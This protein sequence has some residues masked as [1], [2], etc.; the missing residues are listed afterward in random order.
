MLR[1]FQK[2]QRVGCFIDSC[3]ASIQFEPLS[4]VYG[5]NC[6]GKSTLCDILRSLAENNPD[7]MRHRLSIPNPDNSAQQVQ[8][9][10]TVPGQVGEQTMLFDQNG[11][12]PCFP[13]SLRLLVFDTDFIH[14]NVFTGLSIERRNQENITQFVLG[15]ASVR[16]AERIAQKNSRLRALN[17]TLR[18]LESTAFEGLSDIPSFIRLQITHTPEEIESDIVGL[19]AELEE[20]RNLAQNLDQAIIR[21]V[22]APIG[23]ATNIEDFVGRVNTTLRSSFQQAH[24]EASFRVREHILLK[25]QDNQTT[26]TWIGSGLDQVQVDNCPFCGQELSAVAVQL[27]A[28]YKEFF[29]EAFD[30]FVNDITCKL[31]DHEE[32]FRGLICSHIPERIALNSNAC[33]QYPEL[34]REEVY[35]NQLQAAD[36]IAD[37]LRSALDRWSEAYR[38]AE[39]DLASKFEQKRQAMHSATD[40][41]ECSGTIQA[42]GGLCSLVSRYDAAVNEL[43][44]KIEEF[45]EGLNTAHV[46]NKISEIE[47]QV[48]DK[49]LNLRRARS[50]TACESYLSTTTEKD[51]VV[52]EIVALEEQLQQDQNIF[53]NTYFDAINSI[54]SRLGSQRFVISKRISRRGN[55]PTIQLTA[56]FSGTEIIPEKIKSFFS[57]SDRRALAL[58]IFWGKVQPLPKHEKEQTILVLDDPVTS[59]DNGRIDRTI[60]LLEAERLPFRQMIVLSHYNRYLKA[61]FDRTRSHTTG[62]KLIKIEQDQIGSQLRSCTPADFIESPHERMYR[63]IDGFIERRH[64]EDISRDLRVY[65][66]TE[67][68]SRCWH[69]ICANNMV[70]LQFGELLDNLLRLGAITQSQ[71]EN[72]EQ[73]RLSLNPE[74][75][76]WI[77]RE[78]EEKIGLATDIISYIYEEF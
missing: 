19:N 27:L 11:W 65:L 32:T 39:I 25:T 77:E 70:S 14:R 37:E 62:I 52:A 46:N 61:F 76:A 60:R 57:E 9:S 24:E 73:F 20:Q 58:S 43:A 33:N 30:R 40:S 6:Y 16:T 67:V 31:K 5:E 22:P 29:D 72:I 34:M 48:T 4:F 56:S 13:S 3:P 1:R 49:K 28:D 45:K 71:R 36:S 54:F 8:L 47:R 38:E 7:Y 12:S 18:E 75:H 55:M 68:R 66:E 59:F 50:N 41:W 2:I 63:H 44:Q 64:T 78:H 35:R 21:P 74:H 26:E 69:Q 51:E 10:I 15:E 53:L 42:Y 23:M 17:K